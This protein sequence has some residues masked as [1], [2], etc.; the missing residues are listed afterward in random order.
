MRRLLM[1]A[2]VPILL[3]CPAAPASALSPT[4]TWFGLPGL[5]AASGAQWV[6]EYATGTPPTTIYA[7]TEGDGVFKSVNDG[8]T[9]S[10]FSSGLSSVPSAM[11]VRTVYASGLS[12]VWAGTGAGLFKSIS[13]GAFQ[14]VA[15]G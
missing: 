4:D 15:Q 1:I 2:I 14:P 13:G 11:D 7:A 12:T 5:N 9:W 3:L 8:L 6:R 10:S